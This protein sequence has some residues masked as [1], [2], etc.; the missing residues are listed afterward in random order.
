MLGAGCWVP[1]LCS[2]LGAKC[3]VLDPALVTSTS[4][5]HPAP[6]PGTKHPAPSTPHSLQLCYFLTYFFSV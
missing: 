4:T 1:V 5:Q 3:P 6:A 2:V